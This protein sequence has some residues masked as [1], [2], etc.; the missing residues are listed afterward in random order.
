MA[1]KTP[2]GLTSGSPTHVTSSRR[3]QTRRP[4]ARAVVFIWITV[5][6]VGVEG[7]DATRALVETWQRLMTALPDGWFHRETGAV[8]GVTRVPVPTLNGVWPDVGVPEEGVVAALLSRVAATGLP[9]C[10]QLRPGSDVALGELA[11]GRGMKLGDPIPLMVLDDGAVLHSA[12]E[13]DGLAVR[14][15]A[16]GEAHAHAVAAAAG[17]E[18]PEEIFLQFMTPAVFSECGIRSYL[19]EVDGEPVT[20]GLGIA[21][22]RHVGLFNIATPPG[23]RGRGYGAAVTARAALDAFHDGAERAWLQSSPDGYGV[24]ERLG[25]R[26]V[27]SWQCWTWTG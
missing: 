24:Y 2:S 23:H 27:E 19:G 17:F 15:L 10:L 16:S 20:T 11:T 25:F 1:S 21:I 5:R 9:Y 12:Q 26:T 22:G 8:A 7:D 6:A 13:V 14:E 4:H 3:D 18:V